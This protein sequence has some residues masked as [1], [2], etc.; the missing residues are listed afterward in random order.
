[1]KKSIILTIK[2]TIIIAM[3]SCAQNSQKEIVEETK[4]TTTQIAKPKKNIIKDRFDPPKGYERIPYSDNSYGEY[5]RNLPLKPEGAVVKYYDG[6]QKPNGGG[7]QAVVNLP[8]GNKDLHQCAD[9]IMRLRAEYLWKEKRYDEIHFNLTNGFRVDYSEWI[10]GKR[11]ALKGNTT[12]WVDKAH[13][14]NTSTDLW[15]YLEL[16]FTYAGSLSLSKELISVPV[17][18]MKIGD[19][20]IYGG[21]P[22]HAITIVDMA[23]NAETGDTIFMLAQSYMPAQEIHILRNNNA[24]QISPWYSINFGNKLVTPSWEFYKGQLMRF[25]E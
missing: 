14:S 8:I 11:I 3:V 6:R 25:E 22:G 13:P 1:M 15:N 21:T 2:L 18:D 7:Y 17:S 16:I 19:I 4:P 5:L 23:H 9:A 10:K 24:K 12:Y 20:F